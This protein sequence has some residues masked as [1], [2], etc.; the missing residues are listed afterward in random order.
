M[1]WHI[2][3][4]AC[5]LPGAM[6]QAQYEDQS[7]PHFSRW[8]RH[9]IS[10][11]T[12]A[13]SPTGKSPAALPALPLVSLTQQRYGKLFSLCT[14]PSK[15]SQSLFTFEEFLYWSSAL[16]HH[17]YLALHGQDRVGPEQSIHNIL[18]QTI[19]TCSAWNLYSNTFQNNQTFNRLL[20][21]MNFLQSLNYQ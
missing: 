21:S 8:R 16:P 2:S 11:E 10:C 6:I 18:Q 14:A 12:W 3:P 9:L 4:T 20:R 13:T 1:R 5:P 19:H 17:D 15:V 7:I